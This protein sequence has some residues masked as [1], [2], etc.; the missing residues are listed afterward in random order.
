MKEALRGMTLPM[1]ITR[2]AAEPV[3]CNISRGEDSP[4]DAPGF[5]PGLVRKLTI[6][7]RTQGNAN[8][9]YIVTPGVRKVESGGG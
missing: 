3:L 8:F 6:H 7:Q 9:E 4:E 1:L 5:A 2:T